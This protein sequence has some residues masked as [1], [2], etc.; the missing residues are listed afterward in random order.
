MLVKHIAFGRLCTERIS[1]NAVI[2]PWMQESTTP[3]DRCSYIY[4]II[5]LEQFSNYLT[6]YNKK[7][8]ECLQ[9]LF[10]SFPF[11]NELQQVQKNLKNSFDQD[12]CERSPHPLCQGTT[13]KPLVRVRWGCDLPRA[14]NSSIQFTLYPDRL[15]TEGACKSFLHLIES[16]LNRRNTNRTSSHDT[17]SQS[18][19]WHWKYHITNTRTTKNRVGCRQQLWMSK[20][21]KICW[22]K[23]N[24]EIR[25][26][27]EFLT[28]EGQ[29]RSVRIW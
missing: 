24:M 6:T 11:I 2:F 23:E 25:E 3:I 19:L 21:R 27:D 12:C 18:R 8:F 29:Q 17:T 16:L 4:S 13:C 14:Q 26:M 9:I 20:I 28:M 15:S 7:D 5:S 10:Y 22:R 1:L